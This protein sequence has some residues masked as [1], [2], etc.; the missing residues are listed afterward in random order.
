MKKKELL[1]DAKVLDGMRASIRNRFPGTGQNTHRIAFG[2]AKVK[3]LHK[4]P[5]A[6]YVSDKTAPR[7]PG[8]SAAA[9]AS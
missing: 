7:L 3:P 1:V 5:A 4:H 9:S 2:F 6:P 8:P